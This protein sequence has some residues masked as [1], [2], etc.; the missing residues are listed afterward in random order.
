MM[1]KD[2]SSHILV[3]QA[4]S[5]VELGIKLSLIQTMRLA[6]ETPSRKRSHDILD[7]GGL[8]RVA[9]QVNEMLATPSR[10]TSDAGQ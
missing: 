5:S 6:A 8:D 7:F 9:R 2:L 3:K 1:K 4:P 10:R